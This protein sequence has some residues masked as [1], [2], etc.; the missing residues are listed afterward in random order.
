[1]NE[2]IR[3][4]FPR[5]RLYRVPRSVTADY[6]RGNM[7]YKQSLII[8]AGLARDPQE[9]EEVYQKLK[10]EHGENVWRYVNFRLKQQRSDTFPERLLKLFRR[11]LGEGEPRKRMPRNNKEAVVES[12]Y[13][14]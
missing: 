5:Q 7:S 14:W 13:H 9:A 4:L 1:M 6:T 3:Y 11:L 8:R 10:A 2:I 12:R